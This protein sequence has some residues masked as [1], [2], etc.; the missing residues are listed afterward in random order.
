MSR[1][2]KTL[3]FKFSVSGLF[4]LQTTNS[5]IYLESPFFTVTFREIDK[6][7]LL[8]VLCI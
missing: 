1:R 6:L 2:T 4:E 8:S 3:A 5:V 7:S